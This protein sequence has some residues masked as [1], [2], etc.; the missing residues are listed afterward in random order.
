MR[1]LK[2]NTEPVYLNNRGTVI[3]QLISFSSIGEFK[4]GLALVQ[5]GELF[6]YINEKFEEIIP[7]QWKYARAFSE[8]MAAIHQDKQWHFID[9][10]GKIV[11]TLNENIR[12]V[13]AFKSGMAWF[14]VGSFYGY[15]SLTEPLAIFP[16]FKEALD[17]QGDVAVVQDKTGYGV[18][19]RVG[20]YII[21]PTFR[22]IKQFNNSGI[23]A[24]KNS[25]S[26]LFGLI[27]QEGKILTGT[28]YDFIGRFENGYA[29][30]KVG[31]LYG[32][33]DSL[34]NEIL[35]I[36]YE[37]VGFL[38][39][40][41]VKVRPRYGNWQY[42]NVRGRL[43]IKGPFLEA[44][45]FENGY[46]MVVRK[47]GVDPTYSIINKKGQTIYSSTPENR[48]MY[49]SENI[50]GIR[51]SEISNNN[52]N[53]TATFYFMDTAN[54]SVGDYFQKIEP[55]KNGLALV[56]TKTGWGVINHR[57]FFVVEPK[58]RKIVRQKNNLFKAIIITHKGMYKEDGT[59]ILAPVYDVML[60][61]NDLL[62]L[63]KD[64]EVG[65]FKLNE[66]WKLEI[67]NE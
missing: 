61:Q 25:D 5:K 2:K 42:R 51:N 43:M 20:E 50:R 39:D 52:Q 21:K 66:G 67:G 16:K 46:A 40:D 19:N 35:P 37:E 4:N 34:G 53:V 41:L 47:T 65:Y 36:E 33:I 55:F 9:T 12:N 45:D 58:Y 27:T 54:N 10:S 56:K 29:K 49:F 28:K 15:S 48:I 8:G 44:Y 24:Y 63:E 7:C 59:E 38:K 13:G 3:P 26:R 60:R 11:L 23:A 1:F 30:V 62:R 6:G 22:L 14:N 18:I 64:G 31:Y 32:L 57:G 17:F